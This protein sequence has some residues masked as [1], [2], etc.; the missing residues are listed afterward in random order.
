MKLSSNSSFVILV[1]FYIS[2]FQILSPTPVGIQISEDVPVHDEVLVAEGIWVPEDIRVL[3]SVRVPENSGTRNVRVRENFGYPKMFRYST[4][5]NWNYPTRP[6]KM[7]CPHTLIKNIFLFTNV[8]PF[9]ILCN[10][11]EFFPIT[12]NP[13]FAK[14]T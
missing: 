6:E 3:E 14:L 11:S 13:H 5:K 10:P 12:L 9:G 8:Y 7:F 4:E 2:S 1:S